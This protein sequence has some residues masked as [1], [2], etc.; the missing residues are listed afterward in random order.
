MYNAAERQGHVLLIHYTE[1]HR[2]EHST[3]KSEWPVV[4]QTL[5]II[6]EKKCIQF[7]NNQHSVLGLRSVG[8]ATGAE[9]RLDIFHCFTLY[10]LGTRHF[11]FL[12]LRSLIINHF[13][14]L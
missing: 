9:A 4:F 5:T 10:C 1:E 2:T 12:F 3:I 13:D 11:F 14:M 6:K 8:A 7:I